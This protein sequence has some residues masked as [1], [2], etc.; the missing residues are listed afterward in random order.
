VSDAKPLAVPFP[1]QANDALQ[2]DRRRPDRTCT[3]CGW[4]PLRRR[5][6]LCDAC[7][8]YQHRFG[9]LPDK[10]VLVKRGRRDAARGVR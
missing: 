5:N 1:K 3:H 4:R 10:A 2:E 9:Q 6:G 7:N 8:A